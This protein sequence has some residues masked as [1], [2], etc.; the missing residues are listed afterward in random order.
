MALV[1]LDDLKAT[2]A[3]AKVRSDLNVL[4]GLVCD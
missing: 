3:N 4:R 2:K 1:A